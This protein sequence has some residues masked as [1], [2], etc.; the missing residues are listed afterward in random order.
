MNKL[1][2]ISDDSL[3][4]ITL[5]PIDKRIKKVVYHPKDDGLY[6]FKEPKEKYP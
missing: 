5:V 4:I 3:E 6:Y 2:D 1:I